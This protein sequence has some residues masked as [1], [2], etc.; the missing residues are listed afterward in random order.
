M[1][2]LKKQQYELRKCKLDEIYDKFAE[3]VRVR[4]RCQQ[5]KE[6]GKFSKVFLN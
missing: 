3:G 4:S 5:Y 6:G 1:D 2:N